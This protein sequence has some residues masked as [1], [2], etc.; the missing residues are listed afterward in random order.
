MSD[1]DWD[2]E[3][4]AWERGI[5]PAGLGTPKQPRLRSPRVDPSAALP[6]DFKEA[7][8]EIA[9]P[10]RRLLDA[11]D[12]N[13]GTQRLIYADVPE[14]EGFAGRGKEHS[15]LDLSGSP[16]LGQVATVVFSC[17]DPRGMP[18]G[19]LHAAEPGIPVGIVRFGSAGGSCE[20]EIDIPNANS[21]DNGS[22]LAANG[23]AIS[24]P[25]GSLRVLARDDGRVIP[26]PGQ[27]ALVPNGVNGGQ[28]I[29]A[30]VVYGNRGSPGRVY[31]TLFF[32]IGSMAAAAAVTLVVPPFARSVQFFRLPRLEL[33]IT[34]QMGWLSTGG[35]FTMDQFT[36]DADNKSSVW[37]VPPRVTQIVVA[38]NGGAP[39]TSG[40]A[41]FEIAL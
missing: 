25:A 13:I 24:V 23:A 3:R 15:L 26:G 34:L 14:A 21:H 41:V 4:R 40:M 30:H 5:Y 33:G 2:N 22:P 39:L 19:A 12:M 1:N 6:D 17:F 32:A 28:L 37:P 9:P 31:R 16:Q 11:N 38:N 10:L 8:K 36:I 20:V 7:Q 18:E 35:P 29:S 27:S